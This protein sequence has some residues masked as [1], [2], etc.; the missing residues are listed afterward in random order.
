MHLNSIRLTGYALVL[1]LLFSGTTAAAEEASSDQ[2]KWDAE[3]YFW[4]ASLGG[5]T[6]SGNRHRRHH[7][8]LELGAIGTIA[9]HQGRWAGFADLIYLD[10][11]DKANT[12]ANTPGG[13]LPG[14]VTETCIPLR[15]TP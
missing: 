7:R 13:P 14:V 1:G 10:L 5:S 12:V 9:A 4:G 8:H 2:W 11:D 15:R 3:V 6:T